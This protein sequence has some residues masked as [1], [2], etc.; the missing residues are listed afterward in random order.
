MK[1]GY[2]Q[3]LKHY[4]K[5][6]IADEFQTTIEEVV[7]LLRK[8]KYYGIVKAIKP[9]KPEKFRFEIMD[10][11]IDISDVDISS[12]SQIFIFNFVGVII[13]DN[14]VFLCYPKYITKNK[15]PEALREL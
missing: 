5:K 4:T 15:K 14:Y 1:S 8:L 11:D 6:D 3:E 2:F 10:D 7:I 13:L 12:S 9:S